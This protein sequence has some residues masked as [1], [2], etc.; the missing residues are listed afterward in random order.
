MKRQMK[1]WLMIFGLCGTMSLAVYGCGEKKLSSEGEQTDSV[2]ETQEEGT[3][4]EE[5][6]QEEPEEIPGAGEQEVFVR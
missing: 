3:A 1:R 4:P 2:N 5:D 6:G